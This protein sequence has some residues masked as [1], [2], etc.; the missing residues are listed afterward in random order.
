MSELDEMLRIIDGGDPN[1]IVGNSALKKKVSDLTLPIR[2]LSSYGVAADVRKIE[3]EQSAIV[4]KLIE[5]LILSFLML[6][7]L[8]SLLSLMWQL[9]RLYRRRALQNRIIL[10][11]LSTILNTSQDAVIV[12]SPNGEIV[13]VNNAAELMFALTQQD[14]T[15]KTVS[16]ILHRKSD[17]DELLPV[18]G[19][20]LIQS[21]IDGPNRCSNLSARGRDGAVF[22]VELSANITMRSNDTVCVC[23]IRD[24]SRRV[25][26]EEEVLAAQDLAF[27][28]ERSKARFL[29][30][31]SHEMRT[32]LHGI[33]GT[34]DLLDETPLSP[35]Q[36]QYSHVMQSSGQ[37]LLNQIN[38]AL[39][40]TQADGG[41]L[42]FNEKE[43]DLDVLLEELFISQQF[44]ANAKGID[45]E[46]LLQD[47]PFGR[48]T[49]D[50]DRIKQVL[51]N[52]ISNAIKFT[53]EGHVTFEVARIGKPGADKNMMEFQV[54]DTGIGISEDDLPHVFDDF[55][56]T[57]G[58]EEPLTEGTGLGLG[59]AKEIVT[60]LG[61]RIGVE[62]VKG[63]GSLF[64]VRIPLTFVKNTIQTPEE[65]QDILITSPQKILI[66]EDNAT[67]RF[68]ML[69]MLRKDHHHVKQAC[70]GAKAIAIAEQEAFDLI[71]MDVSMPRIDGIEAA[72]R[73]RQGNGAS[74]NTRIVFLT[75]HIQSE[76]D[77]GLKSADADAVYTK[78]LR[79]STLRTLLADNDV[80]IRTQDTQ[81]DGP[82]DEVV[83]DQLCS[84]I[85]DQKLDSLL[86]AFVTEGDAFMENLKDIRSLP[87][88]TLVDTLHRFAGSAAT[89]GALSLQSIL[90]RAQTAV[91]N[92]DFEQA[93]KELSELPVIW[94]STVS[95]IRIRRQAA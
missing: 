44:E 43:F 9:Y 38:H 6:V 15:R 54:C 12:V 74:R 56:R 80:A 7:A 63:E 51:L 52:L 37:L 84:V 89:F 78:P 27:A 86:Q 36:S 73:I 18:S 20:N 68:V 24:I 42:L 79:R 65:K 48:A 28:G 21:C 26:A 95:A 59:I 17:Y 19:D 71:L 40:V 13:D 69:E 34:L 57:A 72:N 8:I 41:K 5:L 83:L 55:Y 35:E 94:T 85:A 76:Q 3:E 93:E 29:G 46:L 33:L 62:S 31:I 75:A 53:F 50:P 14:G 11:R 77:N 49:G 67:S 58:N 47:G 92:R 91:H 10:N 81:N 39:D 30:M 1:I 61:G 66:V 60:H 90:C 2:R 32:P 88:E 64:W 25:A 45:L 82:L 23:F 87:V 16:Q 70:D 4:S 22:P